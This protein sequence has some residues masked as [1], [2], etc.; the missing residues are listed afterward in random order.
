ME[1]WRCKKAGSA[2]WCGN[3]PGRNAPPRSAY[4]IGLTC[5]RCGAAAYRR[6]QAETWLSFTDDR[7]C[8]PCG[9]RY[10]PPTPAWARVVFAVLGVGIL[11]VAGVLTTW[12][13]EG[14]QPSGRG[15][16]T[17]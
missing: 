3:G 8:R 2:M 12:A 1:G 13:F 4:P 5:P 14:N 9:T 10:T 11:V 6:V 17:A 7:V 16:Y 15:S